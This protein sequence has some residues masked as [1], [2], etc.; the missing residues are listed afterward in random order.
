MIRKPVVI[1]ALAAAT[2]FATPV[3]AQID[4]DLGAGARVDLDADVDVR[5]GDPYRYRGYRS[6][7]WYYDDYERGRRFYAEYGGYDCR[8]GYYYTWERDY[9]VRYESWWCFDDR[10]RDYEVRRT[11]VVARID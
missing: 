4:V 1:A 11:R 2:I 7:R 3:Q 9:R 10:G 5:V 8:R 6:E